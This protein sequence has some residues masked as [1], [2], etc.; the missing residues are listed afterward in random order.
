MNEAVLNLLGSSIAE[1]KGR[2]FEEKVL[3]FMRNR[4]S[5]YQEE[6]GNN[7]NLE[8]TPAESTS[9][10]SAILDQKRFPEAHFANGVGTEVATP[11]YTNSTHLP[12]NHTDDISRYWTCRTISRPSTPAGCGSPVSP[13][14]AACGP[15]QASPSHRGQPTKRMSSGFGAIRLPPQKNDDVASRGSAWRAGRTSPYS[16]G[17]SAI[18]GRLHRTS[19]SAA[20]TSSASTIRFGLDPAHDHAGAH[21]QG[22][23]LLGRQAEA[24][25]GARL[26]DTLAALG[27][28]PAAQIVGHQA[29]E[30]LDGLHV[31]F[32][33]RHGHRQGHAL[34]LEH[35]VLDAQLAA[36]GVYSAASLSRKSRARACISSAVSSSKPSMAAI[37]PGST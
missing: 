22:L 1:E 4:L 29:G 35:G 31:A 12:V 9:Y 7:Y 20:I 6:T 28:E 17:P 30:V 15:D 36:F 13:V 16:D 24:F 2:L 37:S 32:A 3:D 33:Q 11:F 19:G 21:D 27:L 25:Q 34:D 26:A 23:G 14:L 10:R 8:A 5:D 18:T